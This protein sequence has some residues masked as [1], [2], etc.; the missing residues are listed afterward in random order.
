MKSLISF[1]Y[2]CS[3]IRSKEEKYIF[4]C[5]YSFGRGALWVLKAFSEK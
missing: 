4:S 5:H 2:L 3:V 1:T